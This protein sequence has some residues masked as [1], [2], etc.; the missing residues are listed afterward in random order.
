MIA[1]WRN[2]ECVRRVVF[3]VSLARFTQSKLLNRVVQQVLYIV[4][5][6]IIHVCDA[7]KQFSCK[8]G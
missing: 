8:I 7:L 2:L 1:P 6:N 4:Y 3:K 5:M